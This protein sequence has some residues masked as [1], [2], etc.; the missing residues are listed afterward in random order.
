MKRARIAATFLFVST[1]LL[2]PP[3][4]GAQAEKNATQAAQNPAQTP[5][6]LVDLLKS[7]DAGIRTRA[8]RDLAKS[9]EAS[10]V[11]A[12]AGALA[13]PSEKVRRE[14]VLGLASIHLPSALE[15][16][17]TATRDTDPGVRALAVQSVVGYYSGQP[18]SAGLTGTMKKGFRRAKG[19]FSE[20]KTQI[21]PGL[22]VDP[23]AV[24]ALEVALQDT[25][26][27]RAAR[28]AAKGLGILNARAAVPALVR[29]AHLFD[30]EVARQSL[31][32]LDK[33]KDLSAGPQLIDLLNSPTKDVKRDAAVTVGILRAR[34]ALPKLQT[35]VENDPD[36]KNREKALNGLAYLGD[37]V[38]VPLFTRELWNQ[39]SKDMR[40]FAA[41]GLA[42]AADPKTL[43]E[44][45][46][47]VIAEKNGGVRLAVQ[48]AITAQGRDDYLSSMV[49]ELDS[50]RH[51]EA[52][53][54]YLIELAR[55]P[56]FLP[57]LYPYLNGQDATVR[58]RLCRVL[59][60]SGDS[61][62]LDHLD[63]LARDSSG[64]VADAALRARQAIRARIAASSR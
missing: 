29:S 18:P 8:A 25:R 63:R 51:G 27:I 52:A 64:D 41:E 3:P 17:I 9:G 57:K 56:K 53:E 21:D 49:T 20:D 38:S 47:A 24:S 2:R 55:N 37:P 61:T 15:A 36:A 62:S 6:S 31:N 40:T 54:A 58:R 5:D 34:D 28:E 59:M 43:P 32:S 12:L 45:E 16:L 60:F 35:I 10:A 7:P 4:L 11:P 1:T 48:F 19:L 22:L 39:D 46:K 30:E 23:K 14:V 13:D 44:L 50:V 42:R 26:S 33:I